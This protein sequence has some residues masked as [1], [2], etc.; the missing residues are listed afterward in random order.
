MDRGWLLFSASA[1]GFGVDPRAAGSPLIVS[2]YD[3]NQGM[4]YWARM[5]AMTASATLFGSPNP[6]TLGWYPISSI[7]LNG[8]GSAILSAN[9]GFLRASLFYTGTGLPSAMLFAQW[10]R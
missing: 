7:S 6:D 9:Y 4:V 2:G 5:G 10:A 1:S 8:S 3:S